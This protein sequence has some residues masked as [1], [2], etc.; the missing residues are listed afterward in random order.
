MPLLRRTKPNQLRLIL[1]IAEVGQLQIAADALNLSQ[2]AASRSLG[3]LEKYIGAP[4]FERSSKGMEP[5]PLG[6]AFV[7]HARVIMSEY[8]GLDS[9]IQRLKGGQ[10]GEVRIGSVTGPAVG[11]L[12]PALSAIRA[13]A[14][15]IDITIEV[16]P[17]NELVRG[18]DEGRFDFIF[19]RIPPQQDSRDFLVHP[20]RSEIVRLIVRDSHP[21]AGVPISSLRQL[22][23]YD[24][25][26]QER[27]SPIRQAVEG[28]FH[29]AGVPTPTRVINSSSLLIVQSMLDQGNAIAPQS[30]EVSTLL[31]GDTFGPRLTQLDLQQQITVLPYFI[32]RNR[33]R[34]LP[35]AA[36]QFYEEVLT[37][38]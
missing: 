3:E 26:I 18:L 32:I 2:P 28:A 22:I 10:S 30:N 15:D 19:A 16:G 33:F 29:A 25:V 11:I 38:L 4:L 31:T 8:A 36:R 17:S 37:R 7:R 1:K 5:T 34:E 9:D 20:A 35:E 14:P 12:M 23:E 27:G 13:T 24:W 21:L 6:H